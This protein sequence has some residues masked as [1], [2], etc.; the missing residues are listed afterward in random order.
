[1]QSLGCNSRALIT[2]YCHEAMPGVIRFHSQTVMEIQSHQ[3]G[4]A[5]FISSTK[6]SLP[7]IANTQSFSI[8]T[9]P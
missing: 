4:M 7:A 3:Q 9:R 5:F 1:M 2:F 8:F 6:I